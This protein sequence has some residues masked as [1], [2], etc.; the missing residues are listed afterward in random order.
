MHK[1]LILATGGTIA[2]EASENGLVPELTAAKIISGSLHTMPDCHIDC[3]DILSLDSSNIQPEEWQIIAR[4][5]AASWQNY[6]GIIITHGTD[7]MGY[8]AS[9]LSYM[10]RNI[11]IPVVLTGSQLP[12]S[13]PLTDATD[14]VRC[15]IAMALSG[16]P[17]VFL[18]FDRK[19]LLGCRGVKVRTSG[20]N[21]FESINYPEV[22][23]VTGAGLEIR[24]ELLPP[25][26]GKFRLEDSLNTHVFLLKLT[27]G[28]DPAIFD[29]L[30]QRQYKGILIEAFGAGGLH[31][32]NR[33]LI[34]KLEALCAADI[35]VVVAS[36]C[37][38]EKSDLS[39]YEVG[40][41]ALEKGVISA[42]DMT[43]EAAFTKLMWVLGREE[44]VTA[45]RKW[46]ETDICHEITL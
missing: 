21:A 3:R 28:I 43:S 39:I 25:L 40:K 41:L 4:E 35:P 42:H 9:A 2:S 33:D 5:V 30:L 45:T 12:F 10:L 17:G 24:E 29:L 15:A 46:F 31:Y 22:A 16:K 38:Y 26:R 11:P 8:T 1:L 7:T 27:P 36:Q 14:N 18:A 23:R 32:V 37:L 34:S 6:D 13:H 20:F 19:V 44:G